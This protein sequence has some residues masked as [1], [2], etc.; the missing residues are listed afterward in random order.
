MAL[1]DFK[2]KIVAPP[3]DHKADKQQSPPEKGGGFETTL[4]SDQSDMI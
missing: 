2:E 4:E 1:T 3:L